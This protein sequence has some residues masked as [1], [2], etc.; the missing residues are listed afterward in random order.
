MS[1]NPGYGLGQRYPIPSEF[2]IVAIK[3][4]S[5]MDDPAEISLL[6]R[7]HWR[8]YASGKVLKQVKI[9]CRYLKDVYSFKAN[10]NGKISSSIGK[11]MT[12]LD[13]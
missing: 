13:R 5:R 1:S 12:K 11:T 8:L 3:K 10:A 6:P 2:C 9:R 7:L 4:L